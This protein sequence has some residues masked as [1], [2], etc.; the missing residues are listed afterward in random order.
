MLKN[1]F[2]NISCWF[3]NLTATSSLPV[4][5]DIDGIYPDANLPFEEPVE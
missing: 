2:N 3:H 1:L 4:G 5:E